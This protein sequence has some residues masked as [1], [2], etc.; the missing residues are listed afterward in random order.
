MSGCDTTSACDLHVT[1]R[2]SSI[3]SDWKIC[4]ET[5]KLQDDNFPVWPEVYTFEHTPGTSQRW[6]FDLVDEDVAFNDVIATFDVIVDTYAATTGNLYQ[7]PLP[8]NEVKGV[9]WIHRRL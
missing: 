5:S 7:L 3:S 2:C 8:G 6:R 1:I 4:G 9:F